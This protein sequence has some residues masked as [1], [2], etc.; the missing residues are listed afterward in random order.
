MNGDV[1]AV[2]GGVGELGV[3]RLLAVETWVTTSDCD[4]LDI[5]VIYILIE[6]F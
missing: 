4:Y 3:S 6:M 1:M 2:F 5:F